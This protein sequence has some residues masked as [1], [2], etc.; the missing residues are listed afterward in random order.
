M[1]KWEG[2][3]ISNKNILFLD[4]QLAMTPGREKWF[5][6]FPKSPERIWCNAMGTKGSFAGGKAALTSRW[7]S[8]PY[9]LPR[10]RKM[11]A[12]FPLPHAPTCF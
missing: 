1:R 2:D 7:P 6:S 8:N 4:M 9:Q 10:L 3:N 12:I 11:G 5:I